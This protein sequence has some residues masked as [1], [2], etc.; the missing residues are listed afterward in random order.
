MEPAS[1]YI[2]LVEAADIPLS[3]FTETNI[4]ATASPIFDASK[5]KNVAV[6]LSMS[7]FII[8]ISSRITLR[9]N[10]SANPN[11]IT[12]IITVASVLYKENIPIESMINNTYKNVDF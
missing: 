7:G 6:T 3:M 12:D 9:P 1:T 11:K 2:K 5:N 10:P 8:Y 4:G